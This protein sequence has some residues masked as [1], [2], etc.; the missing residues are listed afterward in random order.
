MRVLEVPAV[1]VPLGK[2]EQ[3]SPA[4][5]SAT[6]A[7]KH[8]QIIYPYTNPLDYYRDKIQKP[9]KGSEVA[10]VPWLPEN[11]DKN[12]LTNYKNCCLEQ[13]RTLCDNHF[14]SIAS[15]ITPL[16]LNGQ[17]HLTLQ[18]KIQSKLVHPS[19]IGLHF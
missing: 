3:Y 4:Q 2:Q 6:M 12:Y 16:M 5:K 1:R 10:P 19:S 13:A 7:S 11:I 17:R 15:L 9:S 8:S 18:L 14:F